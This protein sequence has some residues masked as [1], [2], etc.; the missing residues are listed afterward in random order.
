MKKI[1]FTLFMLLP[2]LSLAQRKEFVVLEKNQVLDNVI[3]DS[4]YENA[5]A[6][7]IYAP[8]AHIENLKFE[9]SWSWFL[10]EPPKYDTLNSR[11]QVYV[12]SL[13]KQKIKII[14]KEH[15]DIILEID[16]Y[17]LQKST[18]KY[19]IREKS[20][21]ELN[22]IR[23]TINSDP[24]EATL[25]IKDGKTTNAINDKTPYSTEN[26][27]GKV[28]IS[29]SKENFFSK[30]TLLQ[31]DKGKDYTLNFKL[32]SAVNR[33]DIISTPSDAKMFLN[34]KEVSNPFNGY[35]PFGIYSLK[36][37]KEDYEE[38]NSSFTVS[39]ENKVQSTILM[40]KKMGTITFVKPQQQGAD[41]EIAD[42]KGAEV[43]IGQDVV[44]VLNGT[45]LNKFPY[46]K[47]N[48]EVQKNNFATIEKL[49]TIRSENESVELNFKKDLA[50]SKRST[51]RVLIGLGLGG[52]GAGLYLMQ[53]ANKN[54]EAYK[55]ATSSSEASSLRKQV[56][57]ADKMA[58]I[59]MGIGG[60][61]AVFGITINV[62]K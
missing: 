22:R 40:S 31:L 19:E 62:N 23:L 11:W 37:M 35:L 47:H 1:L 57:A 10:N 58:P 9:T 21:S 16:N 59:A 36:L 5:V 39:K 42:L 4:K 26:L 60:L 27:S 15:Q 52:I 8:L 51:K 14:S 54:Y 2:F 20:Q 32:D 7:W 41:V 61:T 49:I 29:V 56:E 3:R 38:I 53:S 18:W 13:Q 43:K 50:K 55:N 30:D 17:F 12:P 46:G 6:I 24:G 33:V 28:A 25:L 45:T 48:L 44:Q 34:N